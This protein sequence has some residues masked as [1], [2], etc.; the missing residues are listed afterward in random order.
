LSPSRTLAARAAGWVS[1]EPPIVTLEGRVDSFL[2]DGW[3]D[4]VALE[5]A[6][7]ERFDVG[8]LDGWTL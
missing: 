7:G 1:D 5:D 4:C 3:A 8:F 6:A 2:V